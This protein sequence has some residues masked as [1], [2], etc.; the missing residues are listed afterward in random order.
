MKA[1]GAGFTLAA[2]A[3]A[4]G[5]PVE[6]LRRNGVIDITYRGRSA[7]GFRTQLLDGSAGRTHVRLRLEPGDGPRF[8]WADEDRPQAPWG[9]WHRKQALARGRVWLAEGETDGLVLSLVGEP[10]YALP[11]KDRA[12][13]LELAHVEGLRE[14]YVTQDR[15]Q[16]GEEFVRLVRDRLNRLGWNGTL[17]VVRPPAEVGG[18]PVKDWG[19]VWLAVGRDRERF[20]RVLSE[21]AEGER[22]SLPE[23]VAQAHEVEEAAP[24]APPDPPP[25]IEHGPVERQDVPYPLDRLPDWLQ[26]YVRI[27]RPVAASPTPFLVTALLPFLSA[28]IGTRAWVQ[29]GSRPLYPSLWTAILGPSTI[30]A[31]STALDLAESATVRPIQQEFDRRYREAEAAWRE[32]KRQARHSDDVEVPDR[33]AERRLLYPS[34]VTWERLIR[35]MGLNAEEAPDGT[36][37]TPYAMVSFPEIAAFLNSLKRKYAAGV[38]ENLTAMYDCARVDY[39]RVGQGDES[40][41][42]VIDVGFLSI[43]GASTPEWFT[44]AVEAGDVEGGFLP[45][46]L[47]AKVERIDGRRA[48]FP[49][50]LEPDALDGFRQLYRRVF[51]MPERLRGEWGIDAEARNLYETWFNGVEDALHGLHQDG[52]AK[53][54]PFWARAQEAALKLALVFAVFDAAAGNG[55]AGVIGAAAM[56]AAVAQADYH[57]QVAER[58]LQADVAETRQ[59]RLEKIIVRALERHGSLTPRDLHRYAHLHRHVRDTYERDAL[60]WSMAEAGVLTVRTDERGNIVLVGLPVHGGERGDMAT[61]DRSTAPGAA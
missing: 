17:Y 6:H 1:P 40:P 20:L 50:R 44:D 26:D 28:A 59:E 49:K 43:S 58:V 51:E 7:V 9:L 32:A 60:L 56:R 34:D 27:V 13:L 46:F 61:R 18:H 24:V 35:L 39:G 2:Y 47:Y 4:K 25:A 52:R 53:L 30:A 12:D 42:V 11:G 54:I 48:A 14:L 15:D 23:A 29:H 38:K 21:L 10:A 8:V 55:R 37:R 22:Y 45:R 36:T 33:P 16:A 57:R 5:I 41:R 19:D 31:K 3:E